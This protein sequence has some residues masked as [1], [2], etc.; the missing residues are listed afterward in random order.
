ML[1]D[2]YLVSS[3]GRSGCHL[4]ASLIRSCSKKSLHTHD[5]FFVPDQLGDPEGKKSAIVLLERKDLFSAVMSMLVGKRTGQW[6]S[7]P[8][9]EIERFKV[10]CQGPESEFVH[11]YNWHKNYIKSCTTVTDFAEVNHLI[12]EDIVADYNYVFTKLKITP[13]VE[14]WLPEKAPY[15]YHDIVINV[16]ECK[17]VFDYLESTYVFVPISK[18][19]DPALPN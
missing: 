4:V 19:Y 1:I 2:N 8:N 9:R 18:A 7:Y 12:F 6:G 10:N 16:E 11:Q 3:A 14:L 15:S 13:V 17:Q 5:P